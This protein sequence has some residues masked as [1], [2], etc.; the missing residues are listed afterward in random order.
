VKEWK[1]GEDTKQERREE[2]KE[3]SSEG[4]EGKRCKGEE[5]GGKEETSTRRCQTYQHH[6]FFFRNFRR[7]C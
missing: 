1:R 6:L 7:L 5:K 4:R 2:K 3:K